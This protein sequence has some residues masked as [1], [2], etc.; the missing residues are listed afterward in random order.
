MPQETTGLSPL[1]EALFKRWAAE[2]NIKDVDHPDSHYDY[3]GFWSENPNFKHA[4]GEHF[5]DKFKQHG[6][7][8]FSRESQYSSGSYDGGRWDGETYLPQLATSRS[9]ID[10]N[11]LIASLLGK[12]RGND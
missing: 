7:P 1:Q 3:R 5:T 4:E 12:L 8:T 6:H 11:Q 9:S 2:N 10:P